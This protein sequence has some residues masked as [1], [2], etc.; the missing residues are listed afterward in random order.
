MINQFLAKFEWYRQARGGIWWLVQVSLPGE[1]PY[2][3]NTAPDRIEQILN[4]QDY[5]RLN[6]KT[7]PEPEFYQA[8]ANI[9]N[10]GQWRNSSRLRQFLKVARILR[11]RGLEDQLIIEMLSDLHKASVMETCSDLTPKEYWWQEIA[12]LL[13]KDC[14]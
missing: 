8:I 14:L 3:R 2:W 12:E 5:T 4:T 7:L 11:Q 6:Y 1:E 13:K 9:P 10:N